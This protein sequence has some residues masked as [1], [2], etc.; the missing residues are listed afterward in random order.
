MQDESTPYFT[1]AHFDG[2][3]S[4]LLRAS[5]LGEIDVEELTELV[6]DAWLTQASR[7]RGEPWL[8]SRGSDLIRGVSGAGRRRRGRPRPR[9]RG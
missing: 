6:Q 8:A 1:T 7:R 5:R 3:P 4:V 9:W 2:H